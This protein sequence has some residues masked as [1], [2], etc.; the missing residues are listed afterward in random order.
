M[1][2]RPD[3]I[4]RIPEPVAANT[5]GT[6]RASHTSAGFAARVG[7]TADGLLAVL[8]GAGAPQLSVFLFGGE[9]LLTGRLLW[10]GRR[11]GEIGRLRSTG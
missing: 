1:L 3:L 6:A 8:L 4:G 2:H 9:V 11:I 10:R 5:I 7:Y